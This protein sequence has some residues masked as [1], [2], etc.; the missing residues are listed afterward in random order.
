LV[1]PFFKF[2][3]FEF[4]ALLQLQKYRSTFIMIQKTF[5]F[6][7]KH[8]FP[9]FLLG[10][11]IITYGLWAFSMG[12]FLDDWYIVL[13]QKYFGGS[14][15][16]QFFSE[17]RPFLGYVYVVFLPIFKD[18]PAAWQL[19]AVLTRWLATFAFWQISSLLFPDFKKL[20]KW[21]A[22][23]FLVYPGFQFHWFAIMYSQAYFL[24]SVYFLSYFFMYWA[25]RQRGNPARSMLWSVLALVCEIIGI[26]PMEYYYGLELVRPFVIY[27][28]LRQE[29]S[30][31]TKPLGRAILHWLPYLAVFA[32]FTIFRVTYSSSYS[33][34]VGILS[35]F[36]EQPM[37][38]VSGLIKEVFATLFSSVL[39][40]WWNAFKQVSRVSLSLSYAATAGLM[41]LSALATYLLL[42][43]RKNPMEVHKRTP[44]SWWVMLAGLGMIIFALAPFIAASFPVTLDFPYNRFLL[45]LAP[46]IGVFLAGALDSLLR[47]DRQKIIVI[48]LLTGLAVGSQFMAGRSFHLL[49]AAQKDFFWQLTWRAPALKPGT[50]LV[51]EDLPFDK[52]SSGPSLTAPLNMIYSPDSRS[53][54]LNNSFLFVSSPQ[55]EA[56]SDFAPGID[57]H[58]SFR[59]L[60]FYG[61]TDSLITFHKPGVGCLRLLSPSD[62]P[63][64]F[65][66]SLR[67]KFWKESIPLSNLDQII[68][69]PAIAAVPPKKYF[70]NENTDQWC[71]YFEKA[72]LARQQSNWQQVIDLFD[73]AAN[74]GF[75]PINNQEW[76]PLMEA[77]LQTGQIDPVTNLS[78]TIKYADVSERAG[79]CKLIKRMQ[80]L[81]TGSASEADKI[82][83]LASQFNC[84]E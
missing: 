35:R 69:D 40:V 56:I 39:G 13:Y 46:G 43:K 47:T 5:Q 31:P 1:F 30:S 55:G 62:S 83:A 66:F 7:K 81:Y 80:P 49:W 26:V 42:F 67:S 28:L 64:E 14:G 77:Y 36:A 52:Y 53:H 19:F 84:G 32:G 38:T 18:S 22:V 37:Q 17:D 71:Y 34:Q 45:S 57:I 44:R 75:Q 23:L 79:V 82:T 73:Q 2:T 76:L 16:L 25:I 58:Y 6:L 20:W 68:L 70:G 72:D 61:N 12:F 21:A 65:A 33:Y 15:F 48:A 9:I 59:H 3:W 11:A 54:I 63:D 78:T 41:L 50:A 10:L 24:L 29:T 51:T 27:F 60:D 4:T 74:K 8:S